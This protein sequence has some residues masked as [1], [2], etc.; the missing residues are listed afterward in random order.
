MVTNC[1]G[2]LLSDTVQPDIV[3]YQQFVGTF[4]GTF[5]KPLSRYQQNHLEGTMGKLSDTFARQVK[6]KGS[7][8]GEKYS[9]GDGL[10]LHVK[11]D[12]KY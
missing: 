1:A 12:G 10:Y 4:V 3:R 2:F 9:D 8:A 11:A 6:H 7:T 5:W